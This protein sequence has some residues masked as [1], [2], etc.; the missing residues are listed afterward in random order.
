MYIY[1]YIR[2]LKASGCSSHALV[3]H[4]IK[5]LIYIPAVRSAI[6][7]LI[8]HQYFCSYL[9]TGT[10]IDA[11]RCSRC[12]LSVRQFSEAFHVC[13]N[14]YNK[15]PFRMNE[16]NKQIGSQ[17]YVS[18]SCVVS[19][20]VLALNDNEAGLEWCVVHDSFLPVEAEYSSL[21][22][23]AHIPYLYLIS[24]IGCMARGKV[25][26]KYAFHDTVFFYLLH[27]TEQELSSPY[28]LFR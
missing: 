28:C 9:H 25:G 26:G 3:L 21:F 24:Q 7:A 8:V 20:C 23:L 17:A 10:M 12:E 6:I 11:F 18:V 16:M 27:L 22:D 15:N 1:Y 5:F 13:V 4:I 19:G 14:E 2:G